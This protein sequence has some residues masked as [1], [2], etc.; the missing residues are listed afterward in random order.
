MP[1][2]APGIDGRYCRLLSLASYP[3]G[4]AGDEYQPI[5]VVPMPTH[6]V[7]T[8][9]WAPLVSSRHVTAQYVPLGTAPPATQVLPVPP[10]GFT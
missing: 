5:V 7:P 2:I 4:C 3:A 6:S 1:V 9:V 8:F 10:P